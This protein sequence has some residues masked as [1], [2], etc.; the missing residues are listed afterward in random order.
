MSELACSRLYLDTEHSNNGLIVVTIISDA[1]MKANV[2][3]GTLTLYYLAER[4]GQPNQADRDKLE[5][6]IETLI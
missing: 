1:T 3:S 5:C 4:G 6:A 2:F